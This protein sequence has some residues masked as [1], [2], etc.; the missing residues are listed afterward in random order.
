M[1]MK[2]TLV[3]GYG[4]SG[5][6]AVVDLLREY[7]ATVVPDVEFRIVKDPYGIT[8][9]YNNLIPAWDA[10]NSDTA[11]RD[12]MW[13]ASHLAHRNSRFSL[14]AGLDYESFFG[15]SFIE[16]TNA[17][18]KSLVQFEY[19]SHW[20]LFDF[21]KSKAQLLK[22]KVRNKLGKIRRGYLI[23]EGPQM[24]F[25]CIDE[26]AFLNCTRR[27]MNSLFA[28]FVEA[29]G[30]SCNIVL[31]Q[32]ISVNNYLIER[33]FFDDQKMIV[34]DRDPRDIYADLSR[35]GNLIGREL[36]VSH[37]A[38]KYVLWHNAYRRSLPQLKEDPRVLVVQFEDLVLNYHE[39]VRN[40]E[41]FI[42]LSSD[43]HKDMFKYFDPDKSSKNIGL[44]KE[45]VDGG[46]LETLERALGGYCEQG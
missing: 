36:D 15:D 13:Y 32:G 11:I 3:L 42:G 40:I 4:W 33:E 10:L 21:K 46:E 39:T 23:D 16:S 27:Y 25:S 20:W 41:A 18:V 26:D 7:D 44:W 37:D 34:V 31:D 28:P 45:T 35:G 9:L 12:F 1:S 8:N 17:Y 38:S 6:S 24:L 2:Y 22:K 19:K 5:S 30:D 43:D 14:T 29:S